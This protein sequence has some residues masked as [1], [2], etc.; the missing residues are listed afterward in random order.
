MRMR[1]ERNIRSL[2]SE[3]NWR[4]VKKLLTLCS[5]L[6]VKILIL[7]VS[8]GQGTYFLWLLVSSVIE[9]LIM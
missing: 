2:E 3:V 4:V 5:E 6:R 8:F 7:D 9:L 1:S